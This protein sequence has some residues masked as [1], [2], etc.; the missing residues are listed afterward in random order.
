MPV[1]VGARAVS[2]SGALMVTGLE[3]AS[4]AAV[5]SCPYNPSVATVAPDDGE[6]PIIVAEAEASEGHSRTLTGGRRAIGVVGAARAHPS[7]GVVCDAEDSRRGDGRSVGESKA[8]QRDGD[9]LTVS[10]PLSHDMAPGWAG[11]TE[12][13]AVPVAEVAAVAWA[14]MARACTGCAGRREHL[15]WPAIRWR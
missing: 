12:P 1:P 8:R 5:G 15:L 4:A 3:M 14:G 13:P 6:A 2:P 7:Q 11:E 9:G 10:V